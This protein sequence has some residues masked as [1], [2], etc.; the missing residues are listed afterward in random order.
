MSSSTPPPR[1]LLDENV[2]ADL[3]AYLAGQPQSFTIRTGDPNIQ[4]WNMQLGMYVQDDIRVRKNLTLS[5][6][7]RYEV[8]THLSDYNNFGPRF[9][10]TWSPGKSGKTTI[11]GSV[12]VFYD[13]LSTGVYEQTL[14]VDGVRQQELTVTDPPYPITDS[15][16]LGYSLGGT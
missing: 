2:R 8:Q 12:G 16:P 11:R 14:R 13:W 5:P 6:G 7:V 1:F 10:V 4:Y 3:D 15:A 9:G